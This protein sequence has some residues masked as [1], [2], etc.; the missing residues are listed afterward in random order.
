M[1]DISPG[2]GRASRSGAGAGAKALGAAIA[3]ALRLFAVVSLFAVP[4]IFILSDGLLSGLFDSVL[5]L[6]VD[7][8]L[9]GGPAL[10]TFYDPAG[11]DRGEGD[12]VYPSSE[13]FMPGSL[14][15]QKYVVY[16]PQVNALW[17]P[18]RDFWQLGITLGSL[19]N[20]D[21]AP[22]GFSLPSIRIY[23]GTG[24]PHAGSAGGAKAPPRADTLRPRAELVSFSKGWDL[25]IEIDGWRPEARVVTASGVERSARLLVVPERRTLW[26]RLPLDLPETERVLD[27]RPTW[28]YVL[29]GASDP[30]A[31]SGLLTV[32]ADAGIQ[33]GG[34]ARSSLTPRIYDV[35]A[36]SAAAQDAMLSSYDETSFSYALLD[37]VEAVS[38]AAGK[39]GGPDRAALER[40]AATEAAASAAGEQAEATSALSAATTALERG[41]ALFRLGRVDEAAPLLETEVAK[42]DVD[43][44][45]LAYWASVVAMR[46]GSSGN[47]AE[48][49]EAVNKAFALLDRA[50]AA[51]ESAQAAGAASGGSQKLITVLMN[52]ASV[53]VAVPDNVFR[54]AKA[55]AA[56]FLRVAE[57]MAA[58]YPDSPEASAAFVSAAKALEASGDQSGAESAFLKA[59]A[60]RGLSASTRFELARRGM[61][62]SV[63]LR[64]P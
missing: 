45:S 13:R 26:L 32:K 20:P 7:P 3:P 33:S 17:S 10:T 52:R 34:G 44:V 28:H 61:P 42:P 60:L 40:E 2:N 63:E 6:K 19:P 38:G 12:L 57:L 53:E 9:S 35:L 15:L 11:D 48:A 36:P 18:E 59:A 21:G 56:D 47:P 16:A 51:A 50:V 58:D 4:L 46:G 27:G 25:A 31:P 30:V 39:A 8:R 29:V 49:I 22:S 37:P 62:F 41:I 43:P 5:H 64:R 23:I 1:S 54:K 24:A 14:D 55:G